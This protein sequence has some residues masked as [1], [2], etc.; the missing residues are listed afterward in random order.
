MDGTSIGSDNARGRDIENGVR[1]QPLP[2]YASKNS[3][4]A[5]N[6]STSTGVKTTPVWKLVSAYNIMRAF[7]YTVLSLK[8]SYCSTKSAN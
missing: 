2:T 8:S 5:K 4:D 7:K 1:G 3:T 6:T